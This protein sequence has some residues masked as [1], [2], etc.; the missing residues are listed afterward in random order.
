M[1]ESPCVIARARGRGCSAASS[2]SGRRNSLI[3]LRPINRNR[4]TEVGSPDASIDRCRTNIPLPRLSIIIWPPMIVA[5]ESLRLARADSNRQY[6]SLNNVLFI[7]T[8]MNTA[9]LSSSVMASVLSKVTFCFTFVIIGQSVAIV[10]TMRLVRILTIVSVAVS[11]LVVP[12][13]VSQAGTRAIDLVPNAPTGGSVSSKSQSS[14][15]LSWVA[16]VDNGSSVTDY[17]IEFSDDGSTWQIFNDGV[18]TATSATVNGLARSGAYVFRVSAVNANGMG[19]PGMAL[20]IRSMSSGDASHTCVVKADHSLWCW[21]NNSRGQIGVGGTTNQSV[22]VASV[23]SVARVATGGE[24]TCALLV[25]TTVKCWGRGDS[26]QL[27]GGSNVDSASSVSVTNLSSVTS[28]AAGGS[29]A[30]ALL[31]DT[32]VQCWGGKW[33]WPV[34]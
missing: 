25:D 34:R 14:V 32:T 15:S 7:W 8:G 6:L 22:P 4:S 19:L 28:V 26:G 9:A 1:R 27:G 11:V 31:A 16:A 3:S 13:S 17:K 30:C 21:G 29:F 18:S 12:T 33:L 5:P 23:D 2:P 24:F 20:G 10:S